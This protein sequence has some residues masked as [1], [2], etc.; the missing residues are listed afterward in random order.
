M[1]VGIAY[2]SPIDVISLFSTDITYSMKDTD[3]VDILISENILEKYLAKLQ[4]VFTSARKLIKKHI[5]II[6]GDNSG[7]ICKLSTS[8]FDK[9]LG[10]S[11]LD[12]N[13]ENNIDEVTVAKISFDVWDRCVSEAKLLVMKRNIARIRV[14]ELAMEACEEII[15]GGGAH[16]S[17][18]EYQYTAT[19][20]AKE[21]GI[22]PRTLLNWLRI[23]RY[24]YDSLT[25]IN[26][27]RLNWNVLE[28]TLKHLK[29]TRDHKYTNEDIDIIYTTILNNMSNSSY[30]R[31]NKLRK[32]LG[33][34]KYSLSKIDEIDNSLKKEIKNI[35]ESILKNL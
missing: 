21:I 11:E 26:K 3:S 19:K 1:I 18:F 4:I 28:K 31:S 12:K 5:P 24:V 33:T 2:H 15:V 32:Y 23:K 25:D 27:E 6:D 14:C 8:L 20:F 22:V 16:W 30:V 35:C 17:N 7:N 34:V 13:I 9:L 10:R 29:L